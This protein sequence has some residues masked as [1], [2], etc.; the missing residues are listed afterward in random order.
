[1]RLIVVL[2]YL[3]VYVLSLRSLFI[4]ET[5]NKHVQTC[6]NILKFEQLFKLCQGIENTECEVKY[7]L[8]A[9]IF[10]LPKEIYVFGEN[11]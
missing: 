10:I 8:F 4:L 6:I 3:F 1:M 9:I 5:L 11:I 7:I 2:P